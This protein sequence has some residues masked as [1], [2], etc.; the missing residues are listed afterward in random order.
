MTLK[1]DATRPPDNRNEMTHSNLLRTIALLVSFALLATLHVAT[2]FGLARRHRP[3]VAAIGFFVPPVAPVA[4]FRNGM[5]IRAVAW[6][7]V[8]AAYVGAFLLAR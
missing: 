5:R 3:L 2:V 8:A 1:F 6:V 4:A 7:V